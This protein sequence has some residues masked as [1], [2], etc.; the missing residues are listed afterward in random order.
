MSQIVKV[1]N[2][3]YGINDM[4]VNITSQIIKLFF[5]NN[6]LKIYRGTELNK[7]FKIYSR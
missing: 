4:Y 5:V 1:I 2:A 3:E 7:L 6:S